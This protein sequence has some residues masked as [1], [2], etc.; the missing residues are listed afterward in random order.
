MKLHFKRIPIFKLN[1]ARALSVLA[2]TALT[3]SVVFLSSTPVHAQ[4]ANVT[5]Q[6]QV[7]TNGNGYTLTCNGTNPNGSVV[8]NCQSPNPIN[9]NNGVFVV[10]GATCAGTVVIAGTTVSEALSDTSSL[11][12]DSNSGLITAQ[13]GGY[14]NTALTVNDGLASVTATTSGNAFSLT[15]SPLTLDFTSGSFNV[16]ASLLG[17]SA[18]QIGGQGSVGSISV[19]SSP[20]PILTLNGSNITTSESLLGLITANLACGGS[21]TINLSQLFPIAVPQVSCS[22][23]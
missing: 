18:A 12:I 3:I 19:T 13:S 11:S 17:I 15:Q 8:L 23:S 7:S 14:T 21:I 16:A 6:C 9:D 1:A 20:A 22:A 4:A 5:L 2:V 10:V